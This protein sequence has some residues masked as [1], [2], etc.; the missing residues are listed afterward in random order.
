[1]DLRTKEVVALF[2]KTSKFLKLK[3]G[4]IRDVTRHL[5]G[6]EGDA[7][8]DSETAGTAT[9]SAA[10]ASA[11]SEAGT[12]GSRRLQVYPGLTVEVRND[13][14]GAVLFDNSYNSIPTG[15]ADL[16]PSIEYTVATN[17]LF[18]SLSNQQWLSFKQSAAT[19]LI[20]LYMNQFNAYYDGV[21]IVI[22]N[23]LAVDDVVPHEWAHG[24][25]DYSSN[26]VYSY[27]SGAINEAMSD[28]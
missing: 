15:V 7:A 21:Q 26:L 24:Y 27:Q 8:A 10:A 4:M 22:G 13:N 17:Y 25:T 2:D 9:T 18:K 23:G 6:T 5:R 16:E 20:R 11:E 12:T 3:Q 1:V 19:L 14:T 28:M